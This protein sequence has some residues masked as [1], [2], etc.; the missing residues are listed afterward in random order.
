M[1][2]VMSLILSSSDATQ[3][4]ATKQQAASKS[5]VDDAA[6][7]V[8]SPKKQKKKKS[9]SPAEVSRS[10]SFISNLLTLVL[11]SYTFASKFQINTFNPF[12]T[13]IYFR[14]L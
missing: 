8:K 14:C 3:S 11:L 13:G 2:F 9:Q 10:S 1:F 6:A 12:S 5:Q 4:N 7:D